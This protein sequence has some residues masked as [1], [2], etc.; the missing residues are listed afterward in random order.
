MMLHFPAIEPSWAAPKATSVWIRLRV[1]VSHNSE[2]AF[3]ELVSK[4]VKIQGRRR[5]SVVSVSEFHRPLPN[6]SGGEYEFPDPFREIDVGTRVSTMLAHAV[7]RTGLIDRLFN[8]LDVFGSGPI[9]F[10]FSFTAISGL[11][12]VSGVLD[13]VDGTAV[14]PLQTRV[15]AGL[16]TGWAVEHSP[17]HAGSLP[18]DMYADDAAWARFDSP[19]AWPRAGREGQKEVPVLQLTWNAPDRRGVLWTLLDAICKAEIGGYRANLLYVLS[20]V[21]QV[22]ASL[23]RL[24]LRMESVTGHSDVKDPNDE[25]V[26]E[27]AMRQMEI[28]G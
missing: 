21:S 14:V 20:R 7:D 1:G 28:Q 25:H 9:L 18:L 15:L 2:E 4:I 16:Q 26:L 3:K 22:D 10:A 27:R 23:G 12:L 11:A 6:Q 24:V 8:S 19:A 13:L 5:M 17:L